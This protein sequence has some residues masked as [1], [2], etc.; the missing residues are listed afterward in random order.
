MEENF[1]RQEIVMAL[2]V[3]YAPPVILIEKNQ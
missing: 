2:L 3:K 1:V